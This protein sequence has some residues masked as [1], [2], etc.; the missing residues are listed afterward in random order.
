MTS[1]EFVA[2]MRING[3]RLI[4]FQ[5]GRIVC[6]R[7]SLKNKLVTPIHPARERPNI[8]Q[9]FGWLLCI[10]FS[11]LF[12]KFLYRRLGLCAC[13]FHVCRD[14]V[15]EGCFHRRDIVPFAFSVVNEALHAILYS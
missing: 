1:Q 5:R 13:V 11:S 15:G 10:F 6:F 2:L 8:A 7:R 12:S 4:L 14:R 3:V 9:S